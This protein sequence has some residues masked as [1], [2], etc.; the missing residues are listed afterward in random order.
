MYH[1]TGG[2]LPDGRVYV[3]GGGKKQG[4]DDKR[5]AEIYSPPYL[6]KGSRPVITGVVSAQGNN[7]I[8]YGQ[9][10]TVTTSATNI[11]RATLVRLPSTTHSLDF[12]QRYYQFP[13][14]VAVAG[15]YR[16]TVPGNANVMPPGYYYLHLLNDMGVPSVATIIKVL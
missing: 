4:F 6:F 11:T 2:L 1:S 3:A 5:T 8:G 15:G 13:L 7:Q 10:F 9:S 12:N 14:P 16:L